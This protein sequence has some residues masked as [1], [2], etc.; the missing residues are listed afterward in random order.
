MPC[1][2][3]LPAW[4]N[5]AG[6]VSLR[7]P[8]NQ[9]APRAYLKLP[10]G[11][12]IGCRK[13]K[14]RE[15]AFRCHLEL[16]QHDQACWATLTYDPKYLPPTLLKDDLS[17]YLKRLRARVHPRTVRFF[18]SGEYG[19][20]NGRPHYHVILFGLHREEPAIRLAWTAGH[21]RVD[22]ISPASIAYVAGYTSKKAG[23][24]YK[25]VR[26]ELVDEYGEV[27]VHQEP[28][29]LMS[30]RP[31]IGAEARNHWK[32]WR[33]QAIHQGQP[34]PVPRYLHAAWVKNTTSEQHQ[35]LETEKLKKPYRDTSKERLEAGRIIAETK[36]NLF[37][38]TRAL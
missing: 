10:C 28:F 33:D 12:C 23:R 24:R 17:S 27:Y 20:R 36:H 34:I 6:V 35:K 38:T 31:G 14:A 25:F 7:E 5:Q 8:L 26:E 1:Y 16:E 30:R 9:D 21:V 11:N 18:G 13:A 2:T 15:W 32:S 19:E 4:R 29:V 3:P 22:P 37:K